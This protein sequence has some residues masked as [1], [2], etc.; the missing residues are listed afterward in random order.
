MILEYAE[1]VVECTIQNEGSVDLNAS[2]KDARD[3]VVELLKW[4]VIGNCKVANTISQK[5][6]W[7]RHASA[8]FT[9]RPSNDRVCKGD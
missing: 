2:L 3:H 7:T 9:V 8:G 4:N 1:R 6:G 5:A